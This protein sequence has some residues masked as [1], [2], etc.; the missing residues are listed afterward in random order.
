MDFHLKKGQQLALEVLS[1]HVR[2]MAKLAFQSCAGKRPD[3]VNAIVQARRAV[4]EELRAIAHREGSPFSQIAHSF[5]TGR[6]R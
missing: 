4:E 2:P 6:T 5:K 1:P 3:Q